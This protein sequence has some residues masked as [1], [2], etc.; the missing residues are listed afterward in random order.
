M[1]YNFYEFNPYD[2]ENLVQALFQRI[3]GGSSLVFGLGADG[4]RELTFR[5]KSSFESPEVVYD[6]L[7]LVQ[8]KFRA[9]DIHDHDQYEWIK[10][11]FISEIRKFESGNYPTPDQYIFVTNAVLT[12]GYQRG[13]RD[14]MEK[15]I[16]FY[17]HLIPHIYIVAYDELCAFILNNSDVRKAYAHFLHPE[18]RFEQILELLQA[19]K[20]S[21]PFI[22]A[23]H[24]IRPLPKIHNYGI[25]M[26]S[27]PILT[28][29]FGTSYSVCGMM[30]QRGHIELVPVV[31]GD[32][33]LQSIISFFKNGSYIIGNATLKYVDSTELFSISFIKRHLGSTN[34]FDVFGEKY[35]AQHLASLIIRSLKISAEEFFGYNFKK[36]VVA[37]PANFSLKQSAALR[38]AFDKAGLNVVRML[39][40]GTAPCYLLPKIV[41]NLKNKNDDFTF[42]V[43]DLGGGTFDL[44]IQEFGD[45]VY[46]TR[47]VLGD[48]S[49]GGMDYDRAVLDLAS[50]R[51][52]EKYPQLH[53][54]NF[55]L[56]QGEAERVKKALSSAELQSF[57]LADQ[58]DGSGNLVDY[59]IILTR[60]DFRDCTSSLNMQIMRH[61]N[62]I[63]RSNLEGRGMHKIDVVMLTGQGAKIFTVREIINEFFAGIQVID[64]YM[65]NAVCL[66]NAYQG[67]VINGIVKGDLLLSVYN[68]GF[69]IKA[70]Q[71]GVV[72]RKTKEIK[73]EVAAL[74]ELNTIYSSLLPQNE[75]VP[76]HLKFILIVEGFVGQFTLILPI[77]EVMNSTGVYEQ[78]IELRIPLIYGQNEVKLVLNID[79]NYKVSIIASNEL[80]GFNRRFFL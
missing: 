67:G 76:V 23:G 10:T 72:N 68:T 3:L 50:A 13:G 1:S 47:A 24:E 34:E 46:E 18:D 31:S 11:Q 52:K 30:S 26:P 74:P 38:E 41:N 15:L 54:F 42:I 71:L 48:N 19:Q 22:L 8:A 7:W 65:E 6:G 29:D 51:L 21:E 9:R 28:I 63:M 43:I 33:L 44:S 12:P 64:K 14:K 73:I 40:E 56:L 55:S 59:S 5:G 20:I 77:F 49:L 60:E 27:D 35:T 32:F 36:V 69:A 2:F 16:E 39:D 79:A 53:G 61:I 57:V 17:H 66:G 25:A 62:N 4:G 70:R 78:V 80:N 37:K 45:G 58:D 75:I